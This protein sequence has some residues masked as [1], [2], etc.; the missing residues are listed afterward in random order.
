MRPIRRIQDAEQIAGRGEIELGDIVQAV[1]LGKYLIGGMLLGGLIVGSAVAFL[2]PPVYESRAVLEVGHYSD[3]GTPGSAGASL[4]EIE[5]VS[6]LI[7]RLRQEYRVGRAMPGL[8]YVERPDRN[9]PTQLVELRAHGRTAAQ[10]REALEPVVDTVIEEHRRASDAIVAT[11]RREYDRVASVVDQLKAELGQTSERLRR[12][13]NADLTWAVLRLDRSRL[14]GELNE[15]QR[16]L[17][18]LEILMSGPYARQTRAI[19]PPAVDD[20]PVK[21]KRAFIMVLAGVASLA[22]GLFVALYRYLPVAPAR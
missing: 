17:A 18:Q 2:L 6:L 10:S 21:P 7:D 5:P 12:G 15:A 16:Q 13:T 1:W 19:V 3:L 11:Q 4:R 20:A 9:N 14:L 22:A 8:V